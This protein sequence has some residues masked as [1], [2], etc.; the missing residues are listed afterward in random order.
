MGQGPNRST[1]RDRR[2]VAPTSFAEDVVAG[3]HSCA[4]QEALGIGRSLN[5]HPFSR[6]ARVDPPNATGRFLWAPLY[7]P[8]AER[9]RNPHFFPPYPTLPSP[10]PPRRRRLLDSNQ[11]AALLPPIMV[12]HVEFERPRYSGYAA[13]QVCCGLNR[14]KNCLDCLS[15]PNYA[16]LPRRSTHRPV[17]DLY[18]IYGGIVGETV[19]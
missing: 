13:A 1:A 10:H 5:S 15:F 4:E 18:F 9:F 8:F 12:G 17:E 19:E 3:G 6:P 11:N 14:A 7:E 2:R 16:K